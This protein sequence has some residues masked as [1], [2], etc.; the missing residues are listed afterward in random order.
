MKKI[1]ILLIVILLG[2][3]LLNAMPKTS[4]A[5]EMTIPE[6]MKALSA[7]WAT[8]STEEQKQVYSK[9]T[10]KEKD[11]AQAFLDQFLA[12]SKLMTLSINASL[13]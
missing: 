3:F 13:K 7:S 2:I 9:M 6:M 8:L 1:T 12:F 10:V 11:D 4:T 5:V